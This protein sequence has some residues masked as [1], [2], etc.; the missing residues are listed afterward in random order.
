[1]HICD[2]SR[3][4]LQDFETAFPSATTSLADVSQPEQ[5]SAFID[6]ALEA[7][8]GVDVL[9][10]NAGIAG[11][12]AYTEEISVA[13]WDLTMAVDISAQFYCARKVIPHMKKA[14]RG[15]I[16]NMSSTA[17]L[18]GFPLRAPYAAAKWAVIGFTKTLAMELGEFGIRA[19]AICPGSVEGARI[20]GVIKRHAA[21]VGQTANEIRAQYQRQTSMRTFVHAQDV[22]DLILFLCSD[23]GSKISGQA[24]TVDG[25]TETLR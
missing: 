12:S 8:G 9:V 3:P 4:H 13:D 25:H 5:V 18:F 10:N 11:P 20:D 1:V 2:I 17:G 24:L 22:A 21:A 15:A 16:I 19:N 23:R 7:L 6:Q 14:R